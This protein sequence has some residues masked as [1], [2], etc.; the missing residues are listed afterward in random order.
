MAVYKPSFAD[1]VYSHF[2]Q[3]A[4]CCTNR[5]EEPF[6]IWAENYGEFTTLILR[7]L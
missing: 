7:L 1:A 3:T 4:R 6:G 2:W 5:Y